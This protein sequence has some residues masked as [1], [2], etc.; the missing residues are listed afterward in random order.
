MLRSFRGRI[1]ALVLGLVTGL[2][3]ATLLAVVL[4]TRA[5]V[6]RQA[7]R[8]LR[9]AADTAR[10]ML[11]FR[12]DQL[13]SA[14]EVLT[15]DFGFKEAVASADTG[16]LLSAIINDRS[17]IGADAILVFGTDGRLLASTLGTPSTR[18]VA[19]LQ[20]LIG[21]DTD[22]SM[23]RLFHLIDGRPYQLVIAPVLAPEPIG[24]TAMAFALNAQLASDMARVLGV[25]VSFVS[26]DDSPGTDVESSSELA[27]RSALLGLAGAPASTPY[28]S[29]AGDEQFLTSSNPIHSKSGRLTLVLQRSL[30]EALRPYALLRDAIL[31]IGAAALAVAGMLCTLLTRSAT[32]PVDALTRAAERLEAGDYS[33][34]VPPASTIEF[35]RLAGAFNAMRSAVADR[36]ATI[37][38]QS[39]HDGL[40]Q[41]P[42]LARISEVL[43]E[44]LQGATGPDQPLVVVLIEIQ[45]FQEIIASLGHP[46]GDEV[47]WEVARRLLAATSVPGRV[48]R[49]ATDQFLVVLESVRA[50]QACAA[51]AG[52]VQG[53]HAAFDYAGLSLQIET[54][55]GIAAYP[56]HGVLPSEL[57]QRAE[58]A[59]YRAK[60]SATSVGL[61]VPGDDALHRHRMAILGQLRRA[62]TDD[63]LQ[64]YYQPKVALADG[65][66]RGCEALVRWLH[67][68]RGC[69]PPGEFIPHAERTGMIR[70]LTQWALHSALRQLREWQQLGIELDVS[71]N[72]SPT[73]L[74]D[75]AF[76]HALGELLR[77]TAADSRHLILE[78]TE[79]AVMK[80][81]GNALRVMEELR[82]LGIRFSIDDF[83]TGYSSLAHLK[84]LPVDELKIDRSFIQEL[85]A[86][87]EDEVIVASTIGLGHALGMK[88]VAE[89]VEMRSSFEALGRL[90]CDLVQGYLIAK[91]LPPAL[92]TAWVVA[93]SATG[94]TAPGVAPLSATL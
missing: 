74:A 28:F 56:D 68:E 49:I 6:G 26:T 84:R 52:L 89:G 33:V 72:V 34:D 67:P 10:E 31:V 46:A 25:E 2:L 30:S 77:Q 16:T 8:Q 69:I 73:D 14:A 42:T 27:R 3:C 64:L 55:V 85:E 81:L 76:A 29:G 13:T 82:L 37:R 80:D 48:A 87:P 11:R 15:S 39:L 41:L 50:Q 61:F 90:G 35:S 71:V 40:T 93:R 23:L 54:R 92:F 78:V 88:V 17:R 60:E 12:G 5:E 44:L 86:R 65:G 70:L 22:A 36:E 94:I 75:P 4:H 19:D 45:Q 32:R 38:H 53:L 62:I 47:L 24:W 91:P 1:L 57:L 9:S 43:Q 66:V 18:T 59:L 63:Q 7:A 58:L 79:G 83:G 21:T 51:V 20:R